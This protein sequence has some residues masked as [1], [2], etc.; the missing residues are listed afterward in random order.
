MASSGTV[1]ASPKTPVSATP[2]K[3]KTQIADFLGLDAPGGRLLLV[4][5]PGPRRRR[6]SS[7]VRRS[8][9]CSGSGDG[10]R[11]TRRRDRTAPSGRTAA[12]PAPAP[13]SRR[14]RRACPGLSS[15]Y[16]HPASTT[17]KPRPWCRRRQ[18]K[19][20]QENATAA[21]PGDR[22][23]VASSW[24]A[25]GVLTAFGVVVALLVGY[26]FGFT[27]LQTRAGPAPAVSGLSGKA[28]L[29]ALSGKIPPEGPSSGDPADSA[30]HLQQ[31]W[32]AVR[33]RRTWRSA[34]V[35]CPVRPPRASSAT[36]S[37]PAGAFCTGQPFA[38]IGGL[39]R[40]DNGQIVGGLRCL[41]IP[42]Y[43]HAGGSSPARPT[44]W[45]PRPTPALPW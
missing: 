27:A 42:S 45:C 13:R 43:L 21:P 10:R 18:A 39:H 41:H 24:G 31:V 32:L 15:N 1:Q 3:A 26:L 22:S 4:R 44:R 35:S 8:W 33:A 9:A 5:A 11:R 19:E 20:N 40:E 12:H 29:T 28:G 7:S 14:R 37:S 34:P 23:C 17:S 36:R 30:L 6:P 2:P 38:G 25:A 16:S